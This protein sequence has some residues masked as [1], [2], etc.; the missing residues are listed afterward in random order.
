MNP[1]IN[2][3][4]PLLV[5]SALALLTTAPVWAD[6]DDDVAPAPPSIGADIPLTYFG[7]APSEV[8]PELIGPYK[9]L[10]AGQVDLEASTITLPLYYGRLASGEGLWYVVTDTSDKFNADALG[11]NHSPKLLY[12]DVG[13]GV[14]SATLEA[15]ADGKPELVF[16]AGGV[17]F[18]PEHNV[19]PGEAPNFFP[20][21]S[22]QPGSVGDAAYS[23]LVRIENAG[24]HVYNAPIIAFDVSAETLN[25]FCDGGADHSIVHDKVVS[26]CPE[27][28]VVTL[29]LF[30]GL[31]FA[32]PVLYISTDAMNGPTGV[33]NPQRQGLNSALSD[34]RGPLNVLGGIPTIA[35]DYSPLWD[36]NPYVWTDEAIAAGYRSRL[37]EEFDILGKVHRGWMTGLGGGEFGSIGLIVN[38]PIVFRFL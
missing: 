18:S 23:P 25:A 24:G 29:T 30:S 3:A 35:T 31:S 16:A 34:G 19:A 13:A 6:E 7:P 32:R 38:C 4:K 5:A 2:P 21:T 8:Q 11:L 14:R 28:G 10:K 26:I 36:L 37:S 22:V 12:A 15:N 17:D 9:L 20:P 1:T 33:D 27:E